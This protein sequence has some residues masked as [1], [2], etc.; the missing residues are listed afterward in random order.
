MNFN[1]KYWLFLVT[2]LAVSGTG[3]TQEKPK[4]VQEESEV[5]MTQ[6]ELESFLTKIATKKKQQLDKKRDR[7]ELYKSLEQ[8]V[9]N[10]NGNF[11]Y[12]AQQ[13]PI[14]AGYQPSSN[15]YQPNYQTYNQGIDAER[16][17]REIDRINS[18]ID[19]VL[20]NLNTNSRTEVVQPIVIPQGGQQ[21]PVNMVVPNQEPTSPQV[22]STSSSQNQADTVV[23][24][25]EQDSEEIKHLQNQ[26]NDL[27]ELIVVYNTLVKETNNKDY[28]SELDSL[29]NALNLLHQ[30]LA[31]QSEETQKLLAE[32]DQL[33]AAHKAEKR[34]QG[35]MIA[36]LES[37]NQ[38][39][40]FGNNSTTISAS[41]KKTIG[42]LTKFIK[43]SNEKVVI[44]ISGYASNVGSPKY[45]NEISLK[46]AEVVKNELIQNG[47]NPSNIVT[48]HHGI[49]K[50]T[51]VNEA[52]RVEISLKVI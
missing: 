50:S 7:I 25:K 29:Q 20:L 30:E 17:Y 19:L 36:Y 4:K 43:E 22:P 21:T 12:N 16:F 13:T 2:G 14:S 10:Y 46:R 5:V 34:A 38:K 18:R 48:L 8:S 23:V 41:D 6:E 1:I 45:N 15:Y 40:Y 26:I 31:K 49:D 37:Y 9:Q 51:N 47:I 27:N 28:D 24:E 32:K 39:I 35:D 11:Q 44:V 3:F 52:R 33:I 42:E